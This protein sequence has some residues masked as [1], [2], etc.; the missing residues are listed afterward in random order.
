MSKHDDRC[1]LYLQAPASPTAKQST[2]LIRALSQG[3]P[4]SVLLTGNGEPHGKV[5]NS[6]ETDRLIDAVQGAGIACLMESPETAAERGAD[7]VH[8]PA[9]PKLYAEA[10][11]L[12]GESANIGVACGRDRHEA[13]ALAEA[14]ADYVGFESG[15]TQNQE[16]LELI[17]WW[18][19]VFVVPNVVFGV[20]TVEEAARFARE[21]ADFVAPPPTVWDE[22]G[23]IDT[24]IEMD[25]AMAANRRAA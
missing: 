16:G 5:P 15:E 10:R 21:G 17:A 23:V 3:L 24:L 12:L 4:A 7:G 13:M 22:D 20:A 19:Q 8:I 14:G 11:A 6:D 9:D 25:R 1:R 2:L 18:S